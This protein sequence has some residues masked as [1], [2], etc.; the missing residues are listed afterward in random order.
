LPTFV[1]TDKWTRTGT[2]GAMLKMHR[3]EDAL[4]GITPGDEERQ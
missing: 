1:E 2:H 4:L 3:V